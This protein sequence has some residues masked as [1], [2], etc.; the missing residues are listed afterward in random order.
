[1][2]FDLPKDD[3]LYQALLTRDS[4]YDG[5]AY[6][7]V[8]STGIFCRLTCPARK[9]KPENCRFFET[10]SEC[11]EAGFRPCKRCHPVKTAAQSDP[12]VQVLLAKLDKDLSRRWTE[13]D[14]QRLNLDPSTVRRAFKRSFGITFLEMARLTRLRSGFET[15]ATGGRVIDA[16]LDA[17]FASPS[18]FRAAFGK[19]LGQ[20][21]GRFSGEPVL[22]ADWIETPLGSM[23]VVSDKSA[24]H[25]L[26]FADR[27]ALPRELKALAKMCHGKLGFGRNAPV[28]LLEA[29]LQAFFAGT[30]ADFTVPLALHGGEFAK[31]VWGELRNI[32]AGETRSYGQLA[33]SIGQP[34]ASRAVARANGANQIALVIPCHR[35]I[36]ADG[37]L[38]GYGGGLWRKQQLIELEA[39]Y[40]RL[41][42]SS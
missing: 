2:M 17:G 27:K 15:L 22:K 13:D 1:M 10:V 25:L 3:V 19:L 38:T 6:V 33:K 32:P 7:G 20:A 42:V 36:G 9:P 12:T 30:C 14:I 8:T 29:Q 41:G 35:V 34:T 39:K 31:K 28:D 23:I 16:Q 37:S 26:E 4:A 21:P 5:R 11:M 40:A 18:A 24:I